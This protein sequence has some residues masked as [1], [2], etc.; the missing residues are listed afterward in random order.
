MSRLGFRHCDSRY[1]FV[2]ND[3]TQPEARWHAMGTGPANYFAD[4]PVGA[5]AE[6]L[7]HEAIR[8]PADLVGIARSIWAVE[9]PESGYATPTL[10]L[11][12]LTGDQTT[13]PACQA[14]AATLRANGAARIEAPSAALLEGGARGWVANPNE[15]DAPSARNGLVWVLFGSAGHLAGWPTV[16]S[17][18]PPARLLPLVHHF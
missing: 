14:E 12:V 18:A 6:F 10:P 11:G 4:T 5:W 17:G 3:A 8:D 2:R 16:E 7:R 15:Q 13:Y 1:P 9:I